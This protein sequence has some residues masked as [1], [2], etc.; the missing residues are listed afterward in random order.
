M[1]VSATM[2]TPSQ[3]KQLRNS[4]VIPCRLSLAI[5]LSGLPQRKLAERLD[6]GQSYI[7]DIA[8]GRNPNIT[9]R[10]ARKFASVFQ[11]RIEDM[12]P[13]DNQDE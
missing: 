7:S 10:N 6:C 2:L 8:R 13:V 5:Q 3:K 9:L 11:V 12:F 4:P 1:G